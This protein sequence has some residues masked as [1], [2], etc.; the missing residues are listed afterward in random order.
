M[1]NG[2]ATVAVACCLAD[3]GWIAVS[4]TDSDVINNNSLEAYTHT[5]THSFAAPGNLQ[6][7]KNHFMNL[8]FDRNWMKILKSGLLSGTKI[9]TPGKTQFERLTLKQFAHL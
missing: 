7:I 5:L 2:A 4:F 8:G 1:R 9:K 6:M 3:D